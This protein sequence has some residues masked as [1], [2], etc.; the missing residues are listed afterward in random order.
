MP[1]RMLIADAARGM[2]ED[3]HLT[4]L[5]DGKPVFA[6]P[7]APLFGDPEAGVSLTLALA[8]APAVLR[9]ELRPRL[10]WFAAHSRSIILV[11]LGAIL[12]ALLLALLAARWMARMLTAPIA[13]LVQ[14]SAEFR[15][16][17]VPDL[18]GLQEV[19]EIA[20]LAE[21]LAAA[22]RARDAAQ[23]EAVRYTERML[24]G[25]PVAV[26]RARVDAGGASSSTTSARASAG[27]P[28]GRSRR[29]AATPTG[30][31]GSCP[32]RRPRAAPRRAACP[33]SCRGFTRAGRASPN[34]TCAAWTAA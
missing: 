31:R 22:F 2:T 9:L 17:G 7:A 11:M 8:D 27:S 23:A 1:L 24:E 29:C 14:A 10:G 5:H 34:S 4:V 30:P 28:A 16:G 19:Q 3:Y 21:A 13:A 18:G 26:F 15:A 33:A 25:L 20:G 12:C 32:T 6:T